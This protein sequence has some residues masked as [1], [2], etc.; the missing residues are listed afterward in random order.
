MR[1]YKWPLVRCVLPISLILAF[2]YIGFLFAI[3][4]VLTPHIQKTE[5][6][7]FSK[8]TASVCKILRCHNPHDDNLAFFFLILYL[9]DSCLCINRCAYGQC[10]HLKPSKLR[11]WLYSVAHALCVNT[12]QA[13]ANRPQLKLLQ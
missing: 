13:N 10:I 12:V 9:H 1:Q 3:F 11:L 8:T 4:Q 6:P 7:S 5:A 2:L